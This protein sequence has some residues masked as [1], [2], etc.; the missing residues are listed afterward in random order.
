[1]NAVGAQL[2]N[3][4][5]LDLFLDHLLVERGLSPNTVS[6]YRSDLERFL[7]DL[8]REKRALTNVDTG[9]VGLH[10]R[11]LRRSGLSSRSIT[12]ALVAI[13]RFYA[14]LVEQGDC[15]ANPAENLKPP[16]TVR[17][18]PKVLSESDIERLIAAPDLD[19][20]LGQRDRAMIEL[21]YATGLRVSEL[22]GLELDQLRLDSGFL[23][24]YGKGRKERIVPVGERA[25]A[26]LGAYLEEA[27]PQLLVDRQQLVFLGARG[28]GL[29]RQGFWKRLKEYGVAVGIG[30]LSPHVLRHS[31]ATHLLDHG[32]DLRAVQLMLGHSDI[33]TTQIYTHIHQH[34]LRSIYEQFPSPRMSIVNRPTTLTSRRRTGVVLVALLISVVGWLSPARA[35]LVVLAEGSVLKVS[36]YELQGER[37][38]LDLAIGGSLTLPIGRIERIVDDE[39]VPIEEAPPEPAPEEP[40]AFGLDFAAEHTVPEVPYGELFFAA[41]KK[42]RVNPTLLA[43]MARAESAYDAGALSVKGARGLMQLM[44][45]TAERFGV[46]ADELYRPERNVEAG[47][48]YVR[49]LLDLFDNDLELVLAAYN[50]GE[51]AVRKH[52][53]VPPYRETRG[54]IK[55]IRRFLGLG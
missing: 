44:P 3:R 33:S 16:K 5:L 2:P 34:R 1:M 55:R 18:L 46:N 50:A 20:P 53:G 29:T 52:G 35:E 9:R 15:S 13:R 30:G 48:R 25:E 41:G 22:V 17:Q 26:H 54:Y 28:R 7:A 32:A 40:P 49:F 31:F 14:F 6:A 37:M 24:A 47:T 11:A 4:R 36:S 23:V 8:D 27:R 38:R 43:A 39:I 45:A 19:S 51:G 42:H 10:V 21:L 12:R